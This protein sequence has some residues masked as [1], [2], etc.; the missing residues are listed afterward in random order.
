MTVYISSI[1]LLSEVKKKIYNYKKINLICKVAAFFLFS[2]QLLL[3]C[4][5]NMS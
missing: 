2:N 1:L 4:S 5:V 3:P